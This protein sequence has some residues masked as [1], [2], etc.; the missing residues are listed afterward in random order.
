MLFL[1]SSICVDGID[2]LGAAAHLQIASTSYFESLAL[3]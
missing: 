1:N 3:R 2:V